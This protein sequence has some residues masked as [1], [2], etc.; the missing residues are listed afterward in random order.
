MFLN[1][2]VSKI[3]RL[4][5]VIICLTLHGDLLPAKERGAFG[6]GVILGDPIGPT[7]KYW[8]HPTVA[9]DAGLGFE[10]D[11]TVY[12]DLLW[13][14]WNVLPKP[15]EGEIAVYLGV[16]PRFEE[17]SGED[18]FGFRTVAGVSYWFESYPI[19]TFL[20]IAPVF[21]FTPDTDTDFDAGLGLRYY[22]KGLSKKPRER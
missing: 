2:P 19:E 17:R 22:F 14:G 11:F 10:S 1:F 9:L 20:E 5:L 4:A 12:M 13:H 15:S 8:F 7:I 16:G 18:K 3:G 6:A 21:Q